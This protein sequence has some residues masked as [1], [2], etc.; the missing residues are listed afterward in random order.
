MA[1]SASATAVSR[2]VVG[3]RKIGQQ[4]MRFGQLRIERR[5]P[6]PRTRRLGRRIH[7]LRSCASPMYASAS[8][9]VLRQRLLEEIGRIGIVEALMEQHPLAHFV[10][11]LG[12]LQAASSQAQTAAFA[13]SHSS[14][15]Q[16][17]SARSYASPLCVRPS[18]QACA[19]AAWPC[20][21]S[22]QQSAG[23]A[24]RAA[25]LHASRQGQDERG[26]PH[27]SI[28]SCTFASSTSASVNCFL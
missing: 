25:R 27:L 19:C 22:A 20:L 28:S 17:P 14:S 8:R 13:C 11:R 18:K 4:L 16:N 2:V 21:R 3:Q 10:N 26:A 5:S 9:R 1:L 6:W 24:A 15:P 23:T 7:P 12:C